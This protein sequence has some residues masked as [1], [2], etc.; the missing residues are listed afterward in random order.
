MWNMFCLKESVF[1]VS[2]GNGDF[3]VEEFGGQK[4]R[5]DIPE[6]SFDELSSSRQANGAFATPTVGL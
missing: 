1:R 3:F 5:V 2:E 6:S 4:V